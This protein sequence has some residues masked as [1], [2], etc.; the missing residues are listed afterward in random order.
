MI[1]VSFFFI[2]D[3][4][5]LVIE[6][7]GF[8]KG[9]IEH[10]TIENIYLDVSGVGYEIFVPNPEKYHLYYEVM[11]HN[12]LAIRENDVNLYGFFTKDEKELFILVVLELQNSICRGL[13]GP[14]SF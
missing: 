13:E 12:Y 7:I 9:R 8:L 6:M 3:I 4:I 11:V 14:F 1:L 5:L 10:I 2:F